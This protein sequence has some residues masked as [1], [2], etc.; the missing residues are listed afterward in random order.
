MSSN[1]IILFIMPICYFSKNILHPKELLRKIIHNKNY[2]E[3][4]MK[5]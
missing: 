3:I 1:Y 4:V 2:F 5:I